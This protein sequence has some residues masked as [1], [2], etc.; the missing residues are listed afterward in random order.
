MFKK[1]LTFWDQLAIDAYQSIIK[2]KPD[3]ATVHFYLGLA[4]LRVNRENKAI[5]SFLRAVLLDK[6]AATPYYHLGK[7]YLKIGKVKEAV[8]YFKHYQKVIA[9]ENASESW[10]IEDLLKDT[11][12]DN[13]ETSSS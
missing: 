1:N 7:A 5:R 6:E 13:F 9:T 2:A 3:N 10:V 12:C 8:R 4:Y 11:M